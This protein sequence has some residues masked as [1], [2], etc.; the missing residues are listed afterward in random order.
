M[1]ETKYCPRC[2]KDKSTKLFHKR[3]I[4]KF[5]SWCKLCK[6]KTKGTRKNRPL[7]KEQSFSRRQR[8]QKF[9]AEY[10]LSNPCVDCNESDLV[11]LQFDHVRGIKKNDVAK[12]VQLSYGIESIKLEIE[13]CEVRC[14]NCHIKRT[15]KHRNSF[16]FSYTKGQK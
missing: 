1:N 10:L 8:N 16:R 12:L 6:K 15:A 3:K 4:G 11:V 5:Q 7:E 2:R 14:S 13:K 9:V